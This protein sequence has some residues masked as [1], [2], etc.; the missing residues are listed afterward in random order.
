MIER[1]YQVECLEHG[2]IDQVHTYPEAI[3]ARREHYFD[4]HTLKGEP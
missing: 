3:K 2:V 1:L 4:L